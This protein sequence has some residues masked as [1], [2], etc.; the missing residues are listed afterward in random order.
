LCKTVIATIQAELGSNYNEIT[1][2]AFL[3]AACATAL[4]TDWCEKWIFPQVDEIFYSLRDNK[5]DSIICDRV[6]LCQTKIVSVTGNILFAERDHLD[7]I[8]PIDNDKVQRREWGVIS[9]PELPVMKIVGLACSPDFCAILLKGTTPQ[10]LIRYASTALSSTS[11]LH[12]VLPSDSGDWYGPWYDMH[13]DEFWLAQ[14][15]PKNFTFGIFDPIPGLFRPHINTH[16]RI[17]Q[18]DGKILSGSVLNRLLYFTIQD[19]NHL[20]IL[21]LALHIFVGNTTAPR[22]TML[23]NNPVTRIMY[24]YTPGPEGVFRFDNLTHHT[25]LATIDFSG[26]QLVPSS[27][28]NPID[29]HMWISLWGSSN[30]AWMKVDLT[31]D[32]NNVLWTPVGSL[33]GYFDFNPYK[34][35]RQEE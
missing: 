31:K 19:D 10:G 30:H 20:F 11:Q 22:N 35:D 23:V 32:S 1:L 24:G 26:I 18:Q 21:D 17:A 28:I 15:T 6:N 12:H 34:I 29:N 2:E 13:T 7:E 14:G 33:E 5:T 25:K 8:V 16:L 27:T 4:I 9:H 3:R